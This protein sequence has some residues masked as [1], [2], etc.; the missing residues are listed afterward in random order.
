MLSAQQIDAMTDEERSQALERL[1]AAVFGDGFLVKDA[2][3]AL[4]VSRGT[5]QRWRAVPSSI[6]PMALLLLDAWAGS[7]EAWAAE[8][9]AN[10]AEAFAAAAVELTKLSGDFSGVTATRAASERR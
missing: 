6:P 8:R 4:G 1:A 2:I 9:L 5:W 7:R 10:V 3:E